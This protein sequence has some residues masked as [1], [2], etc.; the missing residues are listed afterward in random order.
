MSDTNMVIRSVPSLVNRNIN[1]FISS[2]HLMVS[3]SWVKTSNH[4]I[5][6]LHWYIATT[7]CIKRSVIFWS[8]YNSVGNPSKT[9]GSRSLFIQPFIQCSG[10][11]GMLNITM[12]CWGFSKSTLALKLSPMALRSMPEILTAIFWLPLSF[13]ER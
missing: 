4:Q 12:G 11:V 1:S 13:L 6:K 8:I 7:A 9:L 10:H 3:L 2:V 5:E